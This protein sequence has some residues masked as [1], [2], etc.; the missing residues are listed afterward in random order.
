MTFPK[1]GVNILSDF[2]INMKK[3][4]VFIEMAAILQGIEINQKMPK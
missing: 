2:I 1:A 3:L 4:A